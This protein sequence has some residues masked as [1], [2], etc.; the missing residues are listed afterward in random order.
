MVVPGNVLIT[1]GIYLFAIISNVVEGFEYCQEGESG[2]KGLP[3]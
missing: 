3:E 2:L 1:D